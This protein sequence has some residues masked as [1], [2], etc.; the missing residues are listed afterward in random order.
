MAGFEIK[1][2]N[3]RP[4]LGNQVKKLSSQFAICSHQNMMNIM[5]N[6]LAPTADQRQT[7]PFN[8]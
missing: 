6:P 5:F 7:S 4:P 8:L 2:Q 3:S 1:N